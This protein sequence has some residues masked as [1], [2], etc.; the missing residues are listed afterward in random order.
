MKSTAR[1]L[2]LTAVA[3]ATLLSALPDAEARRSRSARPRSKTLGLGLILGAPTGLSG[4]L[5]LG[6]QTSLDFAVGLDAFNERDL[7]FHIDYLVYLV[8][9]ANGGS[10]DVPIYL[11]VGG[12]AWD[13]DDAGGD[14]FHLGARVPFGIA[15]ALRRAPVQFFFEVALRV[16]LIEG[17]NH[18]HRL[19]G[20]SGGLG[21]RVYF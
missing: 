21:F 2:I 14:N 19:I 20:V 18:D 5:N 12:F 15:L 8:N 16:I 1:A 7:Y 11:G 17:D 10:V 4:E 3:A 9:L 13:H 6:G